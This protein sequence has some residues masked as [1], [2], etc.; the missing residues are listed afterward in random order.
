MSAFKLADEST[1]FKKSLKIPD[2]ILPLYTGNFMYHILYGGRNAAKS[3]CVA[4]FTLVSSLMY[5]NSTIL[6][7][8]ETQKS[9]SASVHTLLKRRI[10]YLELDKYF[11]VTETK[12][13]A[14]PTNTEFYFTGL[15][16]NT[17]SLKSIPDI[18]ILWIEEAASI[19]AVSWEKLLPT[20]TRNRGCKVVCTL[21]PEYETDVVYKKFVVNEPPPKSYVKKLTYRDNPFP[22]SEDEIA[23][24]DHMRNTDYDLYMHVYE[25][26]C[27]SHSDAQIFKN[28]WLVADFEEPERMNYYYGIDFGST[29]SYTAIIR[30]YINENTL[31]ITHEVYSLDIGIEE[32]GVV[33]ERKIPGFKKAKILA[34]SAR[35]E[36][37]L[38]LKRRG[39]RVE[40]VEKGKGSI[41]DGIAY[42]RAFDKVVIHPR[43]VNT[44]MEFKLYSYKIDDRSEEITDRI[45]DAYNHLIDALRYAL[46]RCMKKNKGADYK[47][48]VIW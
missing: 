15:W 42:I 44:A 4:D 27:I 43:C 41:E 39:Y 35:P 1:V 7:A 2:W 9:I 23:M 21:N 20:I 37:I 11:R 36:T 47:K 33:A 31:Y 16:S 13:V 45:V 48:L 30:C 18:K 3:F 24:M 22:I 40:G 26:E 19:K 12:I 14:I 29:V 34:D 46:E 28:K 25:G 8:R 17:E 10:K 6:C 32:I 38:F 5:I